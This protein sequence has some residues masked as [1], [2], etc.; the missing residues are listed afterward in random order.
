MTRRAT[1]S[2][3]IRLGL[4]EPLREEWVVVRMAS[5]VEVEPES[6]FALDARSPNDAEHFVEV[7]EIGELVGVLWWF[8]VEELSPA[9]RTVEKLQVDGTRPG[10]REVENPTA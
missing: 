3:S 7:A 10:L 8:D 2:C 4:G 5:A 6:G 1:V 9:E